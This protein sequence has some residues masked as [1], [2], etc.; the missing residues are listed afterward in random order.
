[1][2]EYEYDGRRP[3]ID[4]KNRQ[5]KGV[6]DL[7]PPIVKVGGICKNC[8]EA[9]PDMFKCDKKTK[10]IKCANC[11][12]QFPERPEYNQE[13]FCC[14]RTFCNLYWQ[15]DCKGKGNL[16]SLLFDILT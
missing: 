13:C 8:Y 9:A 10:H 6:N 7:A 14:L 3:P 11:E 16:V 5:H 12:L 15:L 2:A 1:M 4:F